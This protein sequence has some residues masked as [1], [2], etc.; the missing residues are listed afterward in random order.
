MRVIDMLDHGLRRAPHRDC[1]RD[2]THSFTHE[3]VRLLSHQ[4][5]NALRA[6]GVGRG[7]RVAIHSP[8][9]AF[10]LVAMVA[11]LRAGAV[12]QPVHPRNTVAENVDFLRENG[13]EFLFFHS[14]T[15]DAAAQFKSSIHSLKGAVC[16]DE[17][18]HGASFES[19]AKDYPEEFQTPEELLDTDIAWVKATG[20]T[21][22]RSKS[23]QLSQRAVCTLISAF[24]WCMPLPEGHVMLAAT[25]MTH[26]T[27]NMSLCVLANGGTI[28]MLDKADPLRILDAIESHSVTTMF[29]PPTVV[30][31]LISTPGVRER[32]HSSLR[33]FLFSAAPMSAEKLSEALDIFGPVIAQGWGLSEAPLLCTFLA[34]SDY[35]EAAR[36]PDILN[37]CGRATAFARIDILA[38]DGTPSAPG[39]VGELVVRSDLVMAGYLDRPDENAKALR[40]GALYTGDLGYVDSKGF[41]FIV[42]RNK[43]MIISGG[44]NIYPGEI[45]QALWR[46]PAVLDCAVIGVPDAKW[47]EA[48]KAVV[49]LK[50]QTS[51][52][53]EELKAH[54]REVLA[55]FKSPKTI[56]I[57]DDL[58]RSQL[59]KVLKREIRE[60]YWQGQARR[61]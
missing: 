49:Q 61:V 12:W 52:S 42:D 43:D 44:F 1:V 39:Q 48:V 45:E 53:E 15:T 29:L 56:E 17:A 58:P 19:W 32:D 55:A 46:H 28:V 60:R 14:T 54:C 51:T 34:P 23:A 8:N 47:G 2:N 41:Y 18:L 11:T 5:A 21:T 10:V 35:A 31:S 7:S 37:S 9:C 57:W 30:Y 36:N 24:H 50:P 13:T 27:G 25:P 4:A 33:Y 38:D 3:E 20:G 26:A 22:G 6:A 16:L 59:G 40:N